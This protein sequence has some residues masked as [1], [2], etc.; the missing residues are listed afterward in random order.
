[1][2]GASVGTGVGAATPAG[3]GVARKAPVAVVGVGRE[4]DAAAVGASVGDEAAAVGAGATAVGAGAVVGAVVASSPPQATA[5]KASAISDNT[6]NRRLFSLNRS[7]SQPLDIKRMIQIANKGAIRCA[8]SSKAP[9]FLSIRGNRR[10]G[11]FQSLC[12]DVRHSERSEESCLQ[13]RD[14]SLPS[15]LQERTLERSCALTLAPC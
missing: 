5:T 14:S 9:T 10:S 8:E 4:P 12:P 7:I 11:P 3:V 15:R 13:H 6:S 2:A 1:M